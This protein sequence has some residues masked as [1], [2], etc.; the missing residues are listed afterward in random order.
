M[1]GALPVDD[2]TP[3]TS[4]STEEATLSPP[5]S[6]LLVKRSLNMVNDAREWQTTDWSRAGV[7]SCFNVESQG[8]DQL[9]NERLTVVRAAYSAKVHSGAESAR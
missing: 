6:R 4:P 1:S 2:G 8:R 9:Q 7:R 5:V 3:G